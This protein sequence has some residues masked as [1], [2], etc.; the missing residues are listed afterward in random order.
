[1]DWSAAITGLVGA[2]VGSGIS[3]FTLRRTHRERLTADRELAQQRAKADIAL[4]EK[5]L[6]LD[7]GFEIWKRRTAFAEDV[8]ADFYQARDVISAARSP[9]SFEGEGSTRKRA[10]WEQESDSSTLDAYFATTERLVAKREFFAQLYARRYRFMAYF[11]AEAVKPYDDLHK[12]YV[13]VVIAVRMLI[14]TYRNRD[15]GSL[16]AGHSRWKKVIWDIGSEDDVIRPR[17]DQVVAAI[18]AIC[19]PAIRD[20]AE[21][22]LA[23]EGRAGRLA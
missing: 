17:L 7:R 12:I 8:L 5:K 20:I 16:P 23:G 2:L 3:A 9:G 19:G 4:A 13:E 21:D 15:Q 14:D 11:G 6:S 1:M 22:D 18:E 10:D